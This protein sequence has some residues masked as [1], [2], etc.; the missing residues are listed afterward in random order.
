[1]YVRALNDNAPFQFVVVTFFRCILNF[2][3][4]NI[5]CSLPLLWVYTSLPIL[6][7]VNGDYAVIDLHDTCIFHQE[8]SLIDAD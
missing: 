8:M 3:V 5:T 6:K 2:A 7:F 4:Y 1:M